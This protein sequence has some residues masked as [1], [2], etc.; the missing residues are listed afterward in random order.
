MKM[1]EKGEITTGSGSCQMNLLPG[2]Y[3]ADLG[4]HGK[5]TMGIRQPQTCP[6]IS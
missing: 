4:E 3:I 5:I 6:T 2:N 1:Q